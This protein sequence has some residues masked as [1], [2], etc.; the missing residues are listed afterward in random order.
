MFLTEAAPTLRNAPYTVV[1]V[2][3]IIE[4]NCF[5]KRLNGVNINEF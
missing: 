2:N 4:L 3:C 5:T 1:I